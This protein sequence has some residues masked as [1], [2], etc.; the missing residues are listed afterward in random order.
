MP[1]L[2][3]P[4]PLIQVSKEVRAW[5]IWVVSALFLFYKNVIEVSPAILKNE[6]TQTFGISSSDVGWL[7][8]SYFIAYLV[9]QIP[10]ARLLD[11]LGSRFAGMMALLFCSVGSILFSVSHSFAAAFVGRFISGLGASFALINCLRL[12]MQWF[13][14]SQFAMVAGT[15]M[16][17]GMLGAFMGVAPLSALVQESGWRS[18]FDLFSMMG[19]I[20]VAVFWFCAKDGKGLP[21]TKPMKIKTALRHVIE[22]KQAWRLTLYSAF[23]ATP[24]GVFGALWGVSYIESVHKLSFT[25]ST[26]MIS[27]YFL[28]FAITAPVVGWF[29]DRIKSRKKVAL[30]GTFCS[31]AT[32]S[33]ILFIP[34]LNSAVLGGLLFLFGAMSSTYLI[35]FSMMRELQKP[36]LAHLSIAV[37]TTFNALLIAIWD[38]LTGWFSDITSPMLSLLILPILQLIAL[39]IMFNCKE[40]YKK[41]HKIPE[42]MI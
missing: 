8:A 4:K 23:A 9:M 32:L 31:F 33:L 37:M 21:K 13:K 24:I 28:G 27:V 2:K 15:M 10:A 36:S 16:T 42:A 38:P 22:V 12:V 5:A 35:A 14:P 41:D 19:I 11:Q 3:E 39:A 1:K 18:S 26:W 34:N 29:S 25:L 40:T 6:L 7:A 17:V 30:W 20:L